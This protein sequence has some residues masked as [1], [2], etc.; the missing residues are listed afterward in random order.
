MIHVGDV[1]GYASAPAWLSGLY[2]RSG[3]TLDAAT[4]AAAPASVGATNLPSAFLID[5]VFSFA[6]PLRRRSRRSRSS[7]RSGRRSAR[8][9]GCPCPACEFVGQF[10]VSPLPSVQVLPA[11]SARYFVKLLVVPEPSAR[12]TITIGVDGNVDARVV[13]RDRGVVPLR[14]LRLED[15]GERLGAELTACRRRS[16]CTR[17]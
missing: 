13:L 8:R 11:A 4:A 1:I 12:C 7:R 9:R 17:P 6:E 14:D 16:R 5:A 3:A 10:T 15:L 2:V